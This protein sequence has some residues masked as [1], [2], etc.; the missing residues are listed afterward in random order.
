[1]KRVNTANSKK[2][3]FAKQGDVVRIPEDK[4]GDRLYI[5][6][7]LSLP[8]LKK[9]AA[10]ANNGLYSDERPFALVDLESWEMFPVPH[11]SS[12]VEVLEDAT[13]MYHHPVIN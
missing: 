12:R 2:L 6:T 13:I 5:V 4:R 1:M 3:C 8:H 10:E 11:L 7:V 9:A